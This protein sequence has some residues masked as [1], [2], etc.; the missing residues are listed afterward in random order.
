MFTRPDDLSDDAV[1]A[2]VA[3]GWGRRADVI[4]YLPVGFGSHHWRVEA[5]GCRWFVTADD[6]RARKWHRA[7]SHDESLRRLRAALGTARRLRD[8][9]LAF[10]VAPVTTTSGDV[11]HVAA[12][13]FAIAVYPHVQ[14]ASPDS[15]SYR[16][17]EERLAVLDL[18]VGV[19]GASGPTIQGAVVDDFAIPHREDLTAVL[20]EHSGRWDT[21]PY[22]EAARALL[23]RHAREV[24]RVLARYDTLVVGTRRRADRMVLTHGEPHPRNTLASDGGLM[25]VDWD[26]TLLAPPERDVWTLADGDPQVVDLYE[27]TTGVVLFEETLALYRLRWDLTEISIY[28]GQFQRPHRDT[29]DTSMSWAGLNDYLDP[30]RWQAD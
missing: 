25:L 4:E 18:I 1:A 8:D 19:H 9:G 16:T 24:E 2:A 23:A 14:G 15:D 12:N 30:R 13:Y 5:D 28:V 20:T 7:E 3:E 27:A 10:V 11:L 17:R 26:T 6:L 29:T 21:G 22:G